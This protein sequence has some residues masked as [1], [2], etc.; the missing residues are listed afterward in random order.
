MYIGVALVY[1][2]H[3]QGGSYKSPF[4]HNHPYISSCK[5]QIAEIPTAATYV[6]MVM[7]EWCCV[8]TVTLYVYFVDQCHHYIYPLDFYEIIFILVYI[9]VTFMYPHLSTESIGRNRL[10]LHEYYCK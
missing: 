5:L 7:W 6:G 4:P 8:I 3:I 1:K 9:T 2:V 10:L